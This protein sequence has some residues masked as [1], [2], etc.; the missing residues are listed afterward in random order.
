[1][2][3]A[4]FVQSRQPPMMEFSHVFAARS[5]VLRQIPPVE[6]L[7]RRST[8]MWRFCPTATYPC[9]PRPAAVSA[10]VVAPIRRAALPDWTCARHHAGNHDPRQAAASERYRL[11]GRRSCVAEHVVRRS[12]PKSRQSVLRIRVIRDVGAPGPGPGAG[13]EMPVA[14]RPGTVSGGNELDE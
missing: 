6:E 11:T 8:I 2:K 5:R 7:P 3:P 12:A 4:P 14:L 13:R 1:M 10:P 9:Q